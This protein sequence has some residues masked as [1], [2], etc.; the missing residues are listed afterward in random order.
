MNQWIEPPF[1]NDVLTDLSWT[2]YLSLPGLNPSKIVPGIKS[3][4]HLT[5]AG[6]AAEKPNRDSI[7]GSVCHCLVFEPERLHER[8][9]LYQGK[10]R[11]GKEWDAFCEANPGKEFVKANEFEQAQRIRDAVL[12]NKLA[13]EY[14]RN[15][16]H[17]VSVLCE[18]F[19]VQCKGRIDGLGSHL[20]VDLKTTP[21][22][23]MFAFGRVFA[24]LRYAVK[25][26]CYKR[27]A[28]KVTSRFIDQV[29]LITVENKAPFD[30]AVVPVPLAVLENAWPLAESVIRQVPD[31]IRADRWPGIADGELYELHVPNWA[32]SEDEIL[33]WSA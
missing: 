9:A 25:L 27:W 4:L 18:D 20:L 16:E 13:L 26:A 7:V 14:I 23:E 29:V 21:N 17:E 28:E 30:V 15:T 10:T 1:T 12:G 11:R 3:M 33:D 5:A 24:N 19:G 2:E 8:Y 6:A 32:M 31:C 22:I